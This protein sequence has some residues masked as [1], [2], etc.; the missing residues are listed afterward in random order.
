G[1]LGERIDI[2]GEIAALPPEG[3]LYA[4][5]PIGMLDAIKAAW[6]HAGRPA[7]R[8]R[9]EVFG[10]SG[11][12]AE[13]SFRV[14]ILNRDLEIDV[15]PDQTLLDALDAAGVAMIQDC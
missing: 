12:F 5:G 3:E 9:Y 4:C 7:G 6:Q 8:L 11:R 2:A 1:S 14:A 10:D 13:E 15:H